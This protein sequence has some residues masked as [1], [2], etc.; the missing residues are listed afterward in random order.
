MPYSFCGGAVQT[1]TAPKNN[2]ANVTDV[3]SNIPIKKM[4]DLSLFKYETVTVDT[5][6][7]R[8][9]VQVQISGQDQATVKVHPY[10]FYIPRSNCLANAIGFT[11]NINKHI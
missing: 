10:F 4:A 8:S 2:L 7:V 6:M 5:L 3:Q 1:S 9:F 11:K